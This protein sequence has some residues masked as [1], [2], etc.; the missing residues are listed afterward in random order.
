MGLLKEV[1]HSFQY[2]NIYGEKI[3]LHLRHVDDSLVGFLHELEIEGSR[4]LLGNWF[5]LLIVSIPVCFFILLNQI[6]ASIFLSTIL[7]VILYNKIVSTVYKG[8]SVKS[9]KYLSS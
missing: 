9:F 7:C 2:E 5:S 1:K 3:C 6:I 4:T 8:L